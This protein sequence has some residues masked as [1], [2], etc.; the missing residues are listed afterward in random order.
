[1]SRLGL[2]HSWSS[3]FEIG[4]SAKSITII[5]KQNNSYRWVVL[6]FIEAIADGIHHL[7]T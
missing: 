4:S 2:N 1:M 7:N 5:R 3:R 6:S